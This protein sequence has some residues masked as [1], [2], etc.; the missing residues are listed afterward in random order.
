MKNILNFLKRIYLFPLGVL[1][2]TTYDHS[3]SNTS[4][5]GAV[6]YRGVG[7]SYV[8]TNTVDLTGVALV[9]ADIHEVL[10]VPP[11]TQVESVHI[12]IDTPAVGTTLTMDV[13]DAGNPNGWMASTDG[14]A[15]AGT[16]DHS[17]DADE[18]PVGA[19]GGYF[20]GNAGTVAVPLGYLINVT[21]TTATA[22][23]AGPKFRLFA[24]CHD[25]N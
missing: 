9:S 20:Y 13:G 15:T 25:L 18:I 21:M 5:L 8:L 2:G 4:S 7:R 22:I 14:K 1:F 16:Y 23:T 10:S 19:E 24:I 3:G 6:P 11:N 12:V 17:A